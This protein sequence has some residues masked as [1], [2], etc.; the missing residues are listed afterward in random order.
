MFFNPPIIDMP[1]SEFLQE[2]ASYAQT[3]IHTN[4]NPDLTYHNLEHTKYV[5]AAADQIAK[6]YQVSEQDYFI[7]ITAAWF[8]DL[9]YFEQAFNHEERGAELAKKFLINKGIAENTINAVK[10]CILATALSKV[11]SNQLEQIIKDADLFHLGTENFGEQNKRLRKEMEATKHKEISKK[12]WRKETIQL[13]ESH[14]YFTDYGQKYLEEKKQQNLNELKKK[15]NKHDLDK[16][17]VAKLEK[18]SGKEE[19]DK[20]PKMDKSQKPEK[21]IETMFRITSGNSQRLSDQADAKANILITVNS[22]IISVLL[23]TVVRRIE[24]NDFLTIPSL[25]LLTVSLTTIIFSI[26]ATRPHV[27]K[28]LFT[29][30][31][32]EE[33]KVNLLFFGNFYQM[34]FEAYAQGMQRMME[35]KD[36]LY[37]GLTRDVYNQGVVLGKKYRMLQFAYNI[38]MFGLTLSVIA[39]YIASKYYGK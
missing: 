4:H 36:F 21:G 35:D 32:V 34:P 5:V 19:Q 24:T 2:V 37:L 20:K 7:L 12:E 16:S 26:L 11:P 30:R 8:H 17:R 18:N 10:A 15:A 22:I 6:F 38:F 39:F 9:G 14:H 28:G 27:P 29:P 25:M 31:D 3:Y 23:G 1:H 33:K 13:L